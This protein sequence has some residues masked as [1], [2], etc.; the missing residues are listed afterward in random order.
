MKKIGLIGGMSWESTML[1]Y[2]SINTI[3][4]NTL[5]GHHSAKMMIESVNFHDIKEMQSQGDWDA[6]AVELTKCAKNLERSEADFILIC[7]NTM[8]KVAP[9]ISA[10]VNIPVIHLADATAAKVVAAGHKTVGFLGTKFSMEDDF[11]TGRLQDQY[12]LNVLVPQA[13]DRDKVH[14]IIFDELCLGQVREESRA[15][16][17]RIMNDLQQSGAE[18]IILGCTEI[19]LLVNQSHTHIPVFDTTEIHA[20]KAALLALS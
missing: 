6:A 2:R 20:Q 8:H 12:G 14:N 1:Y 7:T 5:G 3:V 17:L 16:Y 4:K 13:N 18:C 10:S 19:I 15:Q 9:Q 11:Y